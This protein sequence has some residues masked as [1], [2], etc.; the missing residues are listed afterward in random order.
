M[1]S[2]RFFL[3]S[4]AVSLFGT[5]GIPAWLSRAVAAQDGRKKVLVVIFLRG[6]MDGLNAVVPHGEKSYYALRPNIAIARESVIDLDGFFGLHPSLGPLKE[7][8]D[9]GHF[10]VIHAA[11]SPDTTR[12][13][14]EAQDYMESGVPP[15]QASGD[16]WLNRAL[17]PARVAPQVRAVSF[18][19]ELPHVLRGSNAAVSIE[20][21]GDFKIRDD[22]DAAVFESMYAGTQDRF[23][24]GTGREMFDAL[25]QIQ[26]LE[27]NAYRPA[28][29]VRYPN[30][31]LSQNL[32]QISRL[33]KAEMGLEVAFTDITGWD[34]HTNEI[35][36]TPV[37]GRLADL[38]ADLA[39]SLA[40]FYQDLGDRM[41]DVS[42][43][44]LSEFGRTAWENGNRGT[45][46]GHA[47][48]MFAL[49]GAIRGGKVYGEWPGLEREQLY[50]GRD[51][52]LT[53]DF[54][55]VVG[56]LVVKHMGNSR[57][58]AVFPGYVPKFRGLIS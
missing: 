15:S 33:V 43:V 40:A 37:T 54:R 24:N 2:R 46:H 16:G 50:E 9:A 12:S 18:S 42:V 13:H 39:Q 48:V 22:H 6:A 45:D 19:P 35:G 11:G 25:K 4:S 17:K 56:E 14:F 58:E 47:G 44:T 27:K 29:N 34:H 49:G 7:I 21:L 1:T 52:N 32:M 36:N 8:Y 23:L 26:S 38:L 57:I 3:K 20:N 53:T 5:A 55:D 10:A 30:G 51:L 41:A 31:R 28:A